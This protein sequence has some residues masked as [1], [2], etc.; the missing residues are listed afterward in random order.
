MRLNEYSKSELT[1][2]NTDVTGKEEDDLTE[3]APVSSVK[4]CTSK[5]DQ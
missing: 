2:E 5:A 3:Q 1:G 4:A